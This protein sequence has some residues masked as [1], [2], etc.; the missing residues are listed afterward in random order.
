MQQVENVSSSSSAANINT[1]KKTRDCGFINIQ[2]PNVQQA[3]AV[4]VKPPESAT[5]FIF[6]FSKTNPEEWGITIKSIPG[7]DEK[8][9]FPSQHTWKVTWYNSNGSMKV[10]NHCASLAKDVDSEAY[11]KLCDIYKTYKKK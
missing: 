6:W 11:V 5:N 3:V 1:T 10:A 2:D 7:K 9:G 8:L 4:L